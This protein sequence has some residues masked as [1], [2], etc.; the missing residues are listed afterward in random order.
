M[1]V[2]FDSIVPTPDG[3]EVLNQEIFVWPI[4]NWPTFKKQER[5]NS[6]AFTC[7]NKQW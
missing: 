3:L 5:V 2:N 4:T 1:T 6:P 7:G